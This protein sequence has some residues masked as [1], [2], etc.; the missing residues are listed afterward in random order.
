MD[1]LDR[2]DMA[3]LHALQDDA[4]N[5]TTES[6]GE[7]VNLAASTVAARIKNLEENGV[8]TGYEPK[9]DYE[10]AGFEQRMLLVGSIQGTDEQIV[11][12][13]SDLE[14]VISVRRLLTDED[15]LHID[16]SPAPKSARKRSP[17]SYTNSASRSRRRASSSKRPSSRSTTFGGEVY[18]RRLSFRSFHRWW[19]TFTTRLPAGT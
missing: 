2:G 12:A 9:I 18:D 10:T 15:D 7:R 5:A 11:T 14:N 16:S 6:I 3:I 19:A 13:V 17:T 4:R 8:I 1:D